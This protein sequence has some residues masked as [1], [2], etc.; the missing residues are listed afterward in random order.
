M[1]LGMAAFFTAVMRTP[2][3]GNILLLEMTGSFDYLS[4]L[5]L[6]TMVSYITTELMG[7]RPITSVLYE[8]LEKK[9]D[10]Q[11][12]E[13]SKK[14]TIF[15][16]PILG[17]S[18]LDEMEVS[19]VK[20]PFDSLLI[21]IKRDSHDIIPKGNTKIL[22]GDILFILTTEAREKELKPTIFDLGTK[23]RSN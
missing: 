14:S 5:I 4:S 3:T 2:L 12:K 7:I 11:R 20:W 16:S 19:K 23:P 18:W 9:N 1:V 22:S 10:V 15:T 13:L 21:K 17:G 6:V 8:N